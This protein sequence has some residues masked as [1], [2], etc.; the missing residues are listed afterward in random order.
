MHTLKVICAGFGFLALS[1][2]VGRRLAGESGV[3]ITSVAFIPLWLI[4]TGINLY[5]GT[6]QGYTVR[7]ELPTQAVAFLLPV[8][9]A[10]AIFLKLR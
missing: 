3:A 4:A 2:F 9:G 1:I 8:A 5:V 7:E 6:K 10:T